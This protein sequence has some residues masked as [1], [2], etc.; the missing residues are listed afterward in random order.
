MKRKKTVEKSFL[1]LLTLGVVI[2]LLSHDYV[3]QAAT[4]SAKLTL[5]FSHFLSEGTPIHKGCVKF[6]ELVAAKSKGEIEVLVFPNA[7]LANVRETPGALKTGTID[8][9]FVDY[10]MLGAFRG[11]RDFNVFVAPF[12][13]RDR[14]HLH[15]FLK[16]PVFAE[17]VGEFNKAKGGFQVFSPFG[18]RNAKQLS[19]KGVAV[20]SPSDIKG[21]RIRVAPIPAHMEIFRAWGATP[22]PVE[23]AELFSALQT[24]MV[25]GEDSDVAS[26]TQMKFYE[27]EKHMALLSHCTTALGL[28]VSDKTW[29]G[30]N[31]AQR[32]ILQDAG[33]E[34]GEF[35]SQTWRSE[36]KRD[37]ETLKSKGMTV[38]APDREAFAKLSEPLLQ[39]WDASA[40]FWRKGLLRQLREVR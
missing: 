38:T 17:M 35:Q 11:G 18:D 19:T 24:G 1:C 31:A 25:D 4:P 6:A 12:A 33:A 9:S 29:D 34:A 39:E 13:F 5:K 10:A 37:I 32:K 3:T 16:S 28:V 2:G 15:A 14:N 26:V 23:Y 21:L 20:K 7:Q 40:K 8:L 27:V 36:E 22:T 30:L